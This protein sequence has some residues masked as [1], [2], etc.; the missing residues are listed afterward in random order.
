MLC[1][2]G[3]ICCYV[4]HSTHHPPLGPYG[5]RAPVTL[6]GWLQAADSLAYCFT[7]PSPALGGWVSFNWLVFVVSWL[8]PL[9]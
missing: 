7:H 3:G 4:D 5:G 8:L 9:T 1:L 2:L 6:E